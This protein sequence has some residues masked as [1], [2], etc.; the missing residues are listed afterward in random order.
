MGFFPAIDCKTEENLNPPQNEAIEIEC[1][2]GLVC[3]ATLNNSALWN[4]NSDRGYWLDSNDIKP[5]LTINSEG[6]LEVRVS[7]A[8][9]FYKT[10]NPATQCHLLN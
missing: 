2:D 1:G 9:S 6:Q 8:N 5:Y 4:M 10:R 3:M 7:N